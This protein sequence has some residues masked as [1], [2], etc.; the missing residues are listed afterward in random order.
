VF[1]FKTY[2]LLAHCVHTVADVQSPQ[3]KSKREHLS[4]ILLESKVYPEKH[5][6]QFE[7]LEQ[8]EQAGI[9]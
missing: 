9:I 4:Q 1:G 7:Q 3:F 6:I 5:E 8:V 2:T